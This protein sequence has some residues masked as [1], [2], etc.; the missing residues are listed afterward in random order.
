MDTVANRSELLSRWKAGEFQPAS[1]E[2]VKR[3]ASF[4]DVTT[5]G[6]LKMKISAIFARRKLVE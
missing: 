5:I 2:D 3:I 4:P 1:W 6:G